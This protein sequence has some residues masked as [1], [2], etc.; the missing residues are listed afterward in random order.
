MD[1]TEFRI[2]G[3]MP[4]TRMAREL[5]VLADCL[6]QLFG[7]S[8]L[9]FQLTP[10]VVVAHRTVLT[11]LTLPVKLLLSSPTRSLL[12]VNMHLTVITA[13][14]FTFFLS[15]T[16]A[17][18][19]QYRGP[20]EGR[21]TSTDLA[22]GGKCM[23]PARRDSATVA[24]P[25]DSPRFC[26]EFSPSAVLAKATVDDLLLPLIGACVEITG[27]KGSTVASVVQNVSSIGRKRHSV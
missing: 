27:D 7:R 17:M 23:L 12:F 11:P 8:R 3:V 13:A 15:T 22:D 6:S 2:D 14:A 1:V 19:T 18:H 20:F 26:G 21:G 10:H 4:Q 16:S 9:L 5:Q 25:G 24:F